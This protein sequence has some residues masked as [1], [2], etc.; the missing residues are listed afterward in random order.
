MS[1]L[2]WHFSPSLIESE[3]ERLL[4]PLPE[5]SERGVHHLREAMRGAALQGGKLTRPLLLLEAAFVV[6]GRDFDVK[7]ALGAACALEL[8]HAYSL[9]HDDLPAMDNA[10]TRRGKPCCHIT[11]GEATAIL[12]GDALQTLAFESVTN[13][14]AEAHTVLEVVKLI[15][16]ATGEAG[17]A[18]GQ[19]LDLDWTN[20]GGTRQISPEQLTQ[21]HALK[22]GALIRVAAHAGAILAGGNEQQVEALRL[23]GEN[24]GRAFQLWDDVLDII[25]DPEVMGKAST[26]SQNDKMTAPAVFGLENAQRMARQASESAVG[27][28]ENFGPEAQTLRDLARFIVQRNK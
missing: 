21:L 9:V 11:Y 25:G 5:S 24:L 10:Q 2:L 23:Y 14:E 4:P 3:L 6:G 12:A 8:I 16:I 22:T 20:D 17:M 15:A 27:A 1:T 13:C 19:A 18:G 7:K 28:L 26:D